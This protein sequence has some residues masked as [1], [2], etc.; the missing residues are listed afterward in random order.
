MLSRLRA[1]LRGNEGSIVSTIVFTMFTAVVLAAVASTVIS[2]MN[3]TRVV[4]EQASESGEG[5]V[6]QQRMMSSGAETAEQCFSGTCLSAAR[7]E[8]GDAVTITVRGASGSERSRTLKT[9]SGTM[10]T[11]YDTAGNPVWGNGEDTT[12]RTFS[13]LA[14]FPD[15]AC[16]LD[17]EGTAW[18]WGEGARGQLGTPEA[19]AQQMEAAPV[20]G[21]AFTALAGSAGG[22]CALDADGAAWCWGSG[23]NGRLGNG[24]TSDARAPVRAGAGT[25]TSLAASSNTTCALDG[26]KLSCW[27]L[28]SGA[29]A[30]AQTPVPVEGTWSAVVMDDTRTCALDTGGK[31]WCWSAQSLAAIGSATGSTAPAEV[32]G[33]RTYS[34]LFM[35][36]GT[37]CGITGSGEAWCWGPN[38]AGQLG[39]GTKDASVIP[40]KVAGGLRFDALALSDASTCALSSGAV[41]CWGEGTSGQLGDGKRTSSLTPVKASLSSA[42]ASVSAGESGWF[43][44]RLAA[45]VQCWGANSHRQSAPT[46]SGDGL[47]PSPVEGLQATTAVG[48]AGNSACTLDAR[49]TIHCWGESAGAPLALVSQ[50]RKEITPGSFTGYVRSPG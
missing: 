45:S 22:T 44:A 33:S 23:E 34:K 37:A 46:A 32:T 42:A 18:C 24:G 14:V 10:I 29:D 48:T 27:G 4:H 5:A 2:T 6:L 9:V 12:L 39:D 11:G 38:Q 16:S 3:L 43:C 50:G 47:S 25:Y 40:V 13:A 28:N 8:T 35:G 1:R 7:T 41:W 19:P 31:A 36:G 49:K 15:H 30:P 17:A 20:T 26:T 21:H